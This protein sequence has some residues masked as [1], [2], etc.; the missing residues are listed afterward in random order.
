MTKFLYTLIALLACTQCMVKAQSTGNIDYTNIPGR[1]PATASKTTSTDSRMVALANYRMKSGNLELTDTTQY[2]YNNPAYGYDYKVEAWK[3]AK[4]TVWLYDGSLYNEYRNIGRTFDAGNHTE[5]VHTEKYA[6]NMWQPDADT[7]Y[8]YDANGN[9]VAMITGNFNGTGW[10][11]SRFTYSY[12]AGGRL[13]EQVYATFFYSTNAWATRGRTTYTY[14]T[15]GGLTATLQEEWKNQQWSNV[16]RITGIYNNGLCI[17]ELFEVYT[18]GNWENNSKL[19]YTYD[20]TGKKI[21]HE[22]L[23]WQGVIWDPYQRLTYTYDINENVTSIIEEMHDVQGYF[24]TRKTEMTYN[25]HNRVLVKKELMWDVAQQQFIMKNN[26]LETRYYYEE[27]TNSVN[28]GIA[29][30]IESIQVSPNP[31]TGMLHLHAAFDRATAASI[32]MTDMTGRMVKQTTLP[33]AR[34]HDATINVKDMPAG[35]YTL[36]LD[37]EGSI[38]TKKVV[39]E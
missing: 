4:A 24:K 12:D 8:S 36:T 21:Q 30:A 39:V 27:F 15:A 32:T 26:N 13:K 5:T 18:A 1:Q 38:T 14:N 19:I 2:T 37:A 28:N 20:A 22:T 31:A 16:Y 11:S 6:G 29:A 10:D 35:I 34:Q 25:G 7:N 23:N 17:E 9:I 33:A 3:Y